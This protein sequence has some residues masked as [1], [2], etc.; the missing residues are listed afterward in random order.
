MVR[1]MRIRY[2]VRT[3]R[4][5]V[6]GGAPSPQGIC[7][8]ARPIHRITSYNVCYTKLL[9][10]S[11]SHIPGTC[12]RCHGDV[13]LAERFRLPTN[14]VVSYKNSVHGLALGAGSETVA[15]CASCHGVHQILPSSDP[16]STIYPGNLVKTCGKCHPGAGTR[17]TLGHIHWGEGAP[18][19]TSV[20]WVRTAYLILIPLTIGLM[21]LV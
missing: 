10:V 1:G 8:S 2:A 4:T 16:R 9:R 20:R 6:G 15:E 14:I 17:F 11:P 12:G 3:P 7:P 18:P 5:D 13:R 21:F 19:P